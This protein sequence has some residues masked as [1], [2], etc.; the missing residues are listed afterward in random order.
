MTNVEG[1]VAYPRECDATITA[2]RTFARL[3]DVQ[4][5]QLSAR[6]LDD[7]GAVGAGVVYSTL[8]RHT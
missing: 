5:P 8:V 4:I 6:C 2:S 1:G 7:S 3:L